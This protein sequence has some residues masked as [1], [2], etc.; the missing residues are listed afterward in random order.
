MI[1]TLKHM[2]DFKRK[3]QRDEKAFKE[4]MT[5][6]ILRETGKTVTDE[7]LDEAIAWWKEKVIYTRPLRSDD[8]K[9]FRMIRQRLTR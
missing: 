4:L 2:L 8:A 9:A 3:E 6:T 7:E 5:A 1:P